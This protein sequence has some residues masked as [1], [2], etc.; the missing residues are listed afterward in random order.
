MHY[1]SFASVL[2]NDNAIYSSDRV[3]VLDKFSKDLE[4]L[5]ILHLHTRFI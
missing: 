4:D 5:L 1:N 3:L 2:D